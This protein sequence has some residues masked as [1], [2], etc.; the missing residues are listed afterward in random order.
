MT[1]GAHLRV[2][3]IEVEAVAVAVALRFPRSSGKERDARSCF[4]PERE[5]SRPS[6]KLGS[7]FV[8]IPAASLAVCRM[9]PVELAIASV[10]AWNP[11]AR[12]GLLVQAGRSLP[13]RGGSSEP[14]SSHSLGYS[15]DKHAL[16]PA[17]F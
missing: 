11:K 7:A 17:H 14:R 10:T 12:A 3:A 4:T 15:R 6:F 8:Q 1:I 16:I 5:L 9:V 2:D 13:S